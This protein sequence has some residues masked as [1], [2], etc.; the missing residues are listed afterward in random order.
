MPHG[1][2]LTNMSNREEEVHNILEFCLANYS[3][4]KAMLQATTSNQLQQ[5]T[6]IDVWQIHEWY[7]PAKWNIKE[8][9]SRERKEKRRYLESEGWAY[10]IESTK[11]FWEGLVSIKEASKENYL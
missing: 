10:A 6:N 11:R 9:W 2:D 8:S 5:V 4:C 3:N 7:G 1:S